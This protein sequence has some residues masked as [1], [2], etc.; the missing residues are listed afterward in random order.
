MIL[1]ERGKRLRFEGPLGLSG[2]A[3]TVV[4]TYEFRPLGADSTVL[5]YHVRM[6]GELQEGVPELVRKTWHHFMVE[7]FKPYIESGQHRKSIR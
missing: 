3:V 6:S 2:M 4:T 1:A 5:T 7:R